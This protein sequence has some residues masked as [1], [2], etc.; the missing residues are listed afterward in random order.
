MFSVKVLYCNEEPTKLNA[1]NV[2]RIT[3][4]SIKSVFVFVFLNMFS[5]LGYAAEVRNLS[6]DTEHASSPAQLDEKK[7]SLLPLIRLGVSTLSEAQAMKLTYIGGKGLGLNDK[8]AKS[9]NSLLVEKY[10]HIEADEVFASASSSLSYCFSANKPKIG[11]A[12]VYL[13]D[14]VKK[15]SKVIL[16]LH[17]YGGSFI[18]YQ[19]FL[20]KTFPDHIIICPAYGISSAFISSEYLQESLIATSKELGFKIQHPVLIGLS[21]G[22]FGGFREYVRN[23][24]AYLGYI[25]LAAFPPDKVMPKLPLEGKIRVVVGGDESFV[26]NGKLRRSEIKLKGRIKDYK[27]RLIA[28][29]GH[30]FMLSAEEE[31]KAILKRWN[32]E[33]SSG[34]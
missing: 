30:F 10:K 9:L 23:Q 19:Y 20:A 17:G 31:T 12:S 34:N 28:N 8:D 33:I 13:P 21:A 22:G 6:W 15:E 29:H 14:K 24:E 4:S 1:M 2:E 5:I 27:S 16:F 3:K 25:C 11:R 32:E 7:Q 18:F 26:K